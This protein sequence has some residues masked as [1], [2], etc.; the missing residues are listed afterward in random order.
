MKL[1][2]CKVHAL[3]MCATYLSLH[4]D[5]ITFLQ[6]FSLYRDPK[7]EHVIPTSLATT[8][9]VKRR[10]KHSKPTA[11]RSDMEATINMYKNRIQ[12]LEDEVARVR[13]T[14]SSKPTHSICFDISFRK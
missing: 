2:N 1:S 8:S 13:T 5:F 10:I 14:L 9:D 12:G 7:G 11:D 3:S 4:F 6:M